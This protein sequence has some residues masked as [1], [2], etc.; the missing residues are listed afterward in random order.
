MPF[1]A[2]SLVAYLGISFGLQAWM[3]SR[4][5]MPVTGFVMVH[6]AFLCLLSLA[7]FLGVVLG[8][9]QGK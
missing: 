4:P 3:R 7:M 5:A 2:A 9:A 1:V 8:V 6:N